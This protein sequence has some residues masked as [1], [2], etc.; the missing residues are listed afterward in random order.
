MISTCHN[1]AH[2]CTKEI[3]GKIYSCHA[4]C[5]KYKE[6]L[7][8]HRIERFALNEKKKIDKDSYAQFPFSNQFNRQRNGGGF[9]VL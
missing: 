8:Q 9:N 6:A 4:F 2:R 3:N 7:I 5:K 1:C